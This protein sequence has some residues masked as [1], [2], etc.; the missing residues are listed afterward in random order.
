MG[1]RHRIAWTVGVRVW[2]RDQGCCV[3]CGAAVTPDRMLEPH[4]KRASMDHVVPVC[5]GGEGTYENLVLACPD[6][7]GGKNDGYAPRGI[8]LG[9]G[10]EARRRNELSALGR[11]GR[12]D[13]EV[14]PTE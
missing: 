9:A 14:Q 7:N 8:N 6:C 5:R 4:K 12:N 1:A 3:Y 11:I 2:V 10:Q 13:M